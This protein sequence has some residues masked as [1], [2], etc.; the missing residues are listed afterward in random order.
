MS[1]G[2]QQSA[3]AQK[4]EAGERAE[5]ALGVLDEITHSLRQLLLCRSSFKMY[6][7]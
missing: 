3:A 5:L 2:K 7:F 6:L 1:L 4:N